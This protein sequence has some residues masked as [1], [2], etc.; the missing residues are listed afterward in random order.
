MNDSFI[1]VDKFR[2]LSVPCSDSLNIETLLLLLVV[3]VVV[4]VVVIVVVAVGKEGLSTVKPTN[5]L[6]VPYF[7]NTFRPDTI[8]FR[9]LI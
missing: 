2:Q 8:I 4:V 3:V 6:H 5:I 7:G 1:N 9:Q